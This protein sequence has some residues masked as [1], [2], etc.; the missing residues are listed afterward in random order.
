MPISLGPAPTMSRPKKP[1]PEMVEPCWYCGSRTASDPCSRCGGPSRRL[2]RPQRKQA[3]ETHVQHVEHP[4]KSANAYLDLV[5]H[6][7][8]ALYR[9]R[10]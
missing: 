6:M 5:N 4:G 2:V 10:I 7:R 1:M 8:R 3:Q 9:A